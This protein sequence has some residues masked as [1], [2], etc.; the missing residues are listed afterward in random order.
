MLDRWWQHERRALV[1]EA[2]TALQ[3]AREVSAPEIRFQLQ[4]VSERV[5]GGDLVLR[6]DS[7]LFKAGDVLTPPAKTL[8]EAVGHQL[9]PVASKSA[10]CV[11][12]YSDNLPITA[13]VHFHDNRFLA[14]ARADAVARLLARAA[15]IPERQFT[16]QSAGGSIYANDTPEN[17]AR[18]RSVE[19]RIAVKRD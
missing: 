7:G 5:E 15:G 16:L 1:I 9:R 18:N 8:L 19:I 2:R 17:R 3:P 10:I 12:G 13:P 11:V 6:F 14:L 4:G